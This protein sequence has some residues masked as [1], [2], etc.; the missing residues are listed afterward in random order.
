M[1]G[2]FF[3]FFPF[4]CV[5]WWGWGGWAPLGG[6]RPGGCGEAAGSGRR[7][8]FL[9]LG[10][11]APAPGAA[12]TRRGHTPPWAMLRARRRGRAG[13]AGDGE[14]WGPREDR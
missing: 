2:V 13:G 14:T 4:F 11:R 8:M 5:V 12:A 3:F 10:P 1:F 6:C 9:R 7:G